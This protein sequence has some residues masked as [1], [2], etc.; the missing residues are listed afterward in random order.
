MWRGARRAPGTSARAWFARGHAATYGG[1]DTVLTPI[2]P[3]LRRR[4]AAS[5]GKCRPGADR[6]VVGALY[7]ALGCAARRSWCAAQGLRT[8]LACHW[9]PPRGATRRLSRTVLD[10][11]GLTC[12]WPSMVPLLRW[13][14]DEARRQAQGSLSHWPLGGEPRPRLVGRG[15]S[16]RPRLLPRSAERGLHRA[17]CRGSGCGS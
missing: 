15:P 4:T 3:R 2:T 10:R 1:C 12:D 13:V 17:V 11:A 14:A 8:R 5:R 6:P 16:N 7:F 9:L